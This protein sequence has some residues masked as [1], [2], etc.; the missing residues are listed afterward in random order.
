MRDRLAGSL[1]QFYPDHDRWYDVRTYPAPTGIAVY[2]RNVTDQIQ[3]DEALRQSEARFRRIFECNMV[4]IAVWT[5]A[6]GITQANDALLDMIG[7]TRAELE[8]GQINWQA[9]TPPEYRSLDEIALNEIATKGVS[10]PYEKVYVCKDGRRIPILIGAASFLDDDTSGIFFAIDLT[11]R[12]QAKVALQESEERYQTL[13]E[14]IDQGFCLLEVL[15][16]A[17][18]KAYD[19]RYLEVNEAFEHQSGL[20]NA[21]GKTIRE[22][23][24][25][26]EPQWGECYEQVVKL[27]ESVRFE[28]DVPSMDR[29]FD[30]YAVPSGAPGQNLV[31]VLF[32][33]I[34]DR[35]RRE[36]IIAT[37]LENT[38]LLRD[39]SARLVNEDEIQVLYDEILATAIALTKADAGTVQILD[40]ATQDLIL[41]A[42]QG[43]DRTITDHFYRVSVS[44]NTSCGLALNRG[45]RTLIDFDVPGDD[46]DGSLQI[47]VNAGYLSAQSTPLISRSGEVI[48]MVS[49][50]WRTHHRPSDRELQFLDLLTRQAADLIERRQTEA[51]LRE[52]EELK[53]SILES[54]KDCIK[55]LTLNSEIVYVNTGGLRLLEVDDPTL[56][57]N[58]RWLDFWQGEDHEN[59]KSAIAAA[60]AGNTGQFQGYRPTHQGTPKWW[61]ILITPVRDSAGQVT[62]LLVVSRD[63]T[64]QKQAET[65]RERLLAQ[66]QA[67]REQAETAN[68]VKDEFLAVLSH[69]LRSPLNPILGWSRLL[70]QGKLD[71]AK[72]K[73]ALATIDRNAQ[74]QAQLVD[75]LLDI[76]GILRG[77]LSL[78]HQ[79]VDLTTVIA[80][81]LETV[82]LA[83]E[84]KAVQ[85]D[86]VI[87]PHRGTVIGDVGRLQQVVWN[88]LSNAV[89]F[90]PAG[91]TIRVSLT[92]TLTHAQLQVVDTGKGIQPDFLPYVFEHFRQE[93]GATTRKFGGLGLGLAIAKQLVELHG[94]TINAESAGVG[95]GATFTIQLPLAPRSPEQ[96]CPAPTATEMNDLNGVRI[97][98]IDDEPDSR[99]LVAFVLEQANASVTSAA[100][101]WEALQTVEQFVPD[102]IVSDIGM[103]EMDGYMLMQQLR[104][105]E[106]I[107][108]VPAIALTAYAGEFDR[109]Q[110]IASGFQ[111]HLPKPVDPD[112]IVKSV[113]A[114]MQSSQKSQS[115]TSRSG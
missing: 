5:V 115:A 43:F 16:D 9:L 84:A 111:T 83:A 76:S 49:T 3:A 62:Q 23:V 106:S 42:A 51:A 63:I 90:T 66:E 103:P 102:L 109:Q 110:A 61:D 104:E 81:A 31:S 108:L 67:A 75:D 86:T 64:K 88:L 17:N 56:M 65:E 20:T 24:P 19:Y 95:Q 27:R 107:Q 21:V 97:L 96:L 38:R 71:A 4:P 18:D 57:L 10:V 70:Q 13:F 32:T 74:L 99:E 87:S 44:S 47:H 14:S 36:A 58:A 34:T 6:G 80:A 22:L 92:E 68:R 11:D 93:D 39:L 2:F 1:T 73:T 82:R 91:G 48:G 69:E 37:D 89:K 25:N 53:Q 12:K 54:S 72:T 85:I 79:P 78:N 94:G 26:L 52:S 112:A 113:I 45:T 28:A 30:I 40:D 60:K 15:F 29:V 105:I 77:K 7:Y 8:T 55:V 101:A 46:P 41:L 50:H 59:A 35:K 33:D 100:S 98:V 114:L